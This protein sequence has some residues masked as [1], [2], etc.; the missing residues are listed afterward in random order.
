MGS[1]IDQ[2]VLI[3]YEKTFKITDDKMIFR[4]ILEGILT[5]SPFDDNFYCIVSFK[6]LH[7]H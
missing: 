7:I 1:M 3:L 5:F 2:M 4:D 6:F